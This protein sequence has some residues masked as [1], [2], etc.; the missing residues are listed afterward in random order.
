MNLKL[1]QIFTS[2]LSALVVAPTRVKPNELMPFLAQLGPILPLLCLSMT[3]KA[4]ATVNIG[5]FDLSRNGLACRGQ[6]NPASSV[7]Q[8]G[9][10]LDLHSRM[11]WKRLKQTFDSAMTNSDQLESY[12]QFF[13]EV[14]GSPWG[15]DRLALAKRLGFDFKNK[16]APKLTSLLTSIDREIASHLTSWNHNHQTELGRQDVIHIAFPFRKINL[17]GKWDWI[18]LRYLEPVP[19]GYEPYIEEENVNY[20]P[21]GKALYKALDD[22]YF[23]LFVVKRAEGGLFINFTLDHEIFGH[24]LTYILRPDYAASY[25]TIVRQVVEDGGWRDAMR[26][27][28]AIR[29]LYYN[30]ALVL[31]DKATLNYRIT[32][33]PVPED[34]RPEF[35]DLG[36]A[37]QDIDRMV[38]AMTSQEIFN[39]AAELRR[40]LPYVT[41]H[42]GGLVSQF[43]GSPHE[44]IPHNNN[45]VFGDLMYLEGREWEQITASN[46]AAHV[47]SEIREEFARVLRMIYALSELTLEDWSQAVTAEEPPHNVELFHAAFGVSTEELD[48][49]ANTGQLKGP[50]INMAAA[51]S[52]NFWDRQSPNSLQ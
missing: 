33:L 39:T 26:T 36:Y 27:G 49:L 18:H 25:R 8:S 40:S 41:K 20:V 12:Q 42:L 52:L 35:G 13:A 15:Q 31:I 46:L 19:P 3:L 10:L 48:Y 17:E 21:P 24:F 50:Q 28:R 6:L 51:F 47:E 38:T 1:I 44:S 45:P 30:E 4:N 34:A 16:R 29:L 11:M 14:E 22:G 43:S 23:P 37:K 2:L 5:T 32:N 9:K 7:Y